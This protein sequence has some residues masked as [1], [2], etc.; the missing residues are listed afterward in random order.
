[1]T[2]DTPEH[3]QAAP[4]SDTPPQSI[5]PADLVL[6]S[7]GHDPD[8]SKP[9]PVPPTP[10]R[11][12]IGLMIALA[13]CLLLLIGV[14]FILPRVIPPQISKPTKP[15]ELTNTE[16]SSLLVD[17]PPIDQVAIALARREAQDALARIKEKQTLLLNR[18]VS[19]W[20]PEEYKAALDTIQQGDTHYRQQRYSE[21]L[22]SYT[23][24][25]TALKQLASQIEPR[26]TQAL[27]NGLTAL[28]QGDAEQALV[29]FQLALA[30]E[31]SDLSKTN[32]SEL[33]PSET[34]PSSANLS[35]AHRGLARAKLLPQVMAHV[36]E[37][38]QLLQNNLPAAALS[39]FSAA[40]SLDSKHPLAQSGHKQAQ[41]AIDNAA[42][43]SAMSAGFQHMDSGDFQRAMSSFKAALAASPE[44]D[45]ARSALTQAQNRRTQHQIQT[46][47]SRAL[48][49]EAQENWQQALELYREALEKDSAVSASRIGEIRTSTRAALDQA[50]DSVLADPLAL[51]ASSRYRQ[52][53]QVL[54]DAQGIKQ[55]GPKLRQQISDLQQTL[56]L[57]RQPV[58]LTL[59]SDNATHIT[60]LRVGDLGSFQSKAITLIP[61][62]YIA[63][64]YRPGYR[65]VRVE[66]K[67]TSAVTGAM[68][69]SLTSSQPS[70][71]TVRI[72]CYETI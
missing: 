61:G 10:H 7:P 4:T 33:N 58:A 72:Q 41:Q 69:G 19:V 9:T 21:A 6:S 23:Q 32:P 3:T 59:Q 44:S 27:D 42:Y 15:P 17:S 31:E 63:T 20:A 29:Q 39:A 62:R 28:E 11:S 50:I 66:F 37:G 68:T 12:R 53:E 54:R 55:P 49:N 14:I 24:G 45:A 38:E 18:N 13:V 65:D 16:T 1:M 67:V 35:I 71:Q 25:E 70:A 22:S 34:K 26:L 2:K 52:G 46:L 36:S 8:S 5:R 48:N 47:L 51:A 40:L 60:L 56:S 64:G 43:Q 30:L 57:A